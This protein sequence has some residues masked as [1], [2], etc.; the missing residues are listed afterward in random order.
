MDGILFGENSAPLSLRA[1]FK[2]EFLQTGEVVAPEVLYTL[3]SY[4]SEFTLGLTPHFVDIAND[5]K[6]LM[7]AGTIV[8]VGSNSGSFLDACAANGLSALGIEP[9]SALV[10]LC[11]QRG[12]RAVCSYFSQESA[13]QLQSSGEKFSA[14]Y[15]ANTLANIDDVA[16]FFE[17][18]ALLLDKG[19][20]IIVDTQDQ[21]A[22]IEHCLVDTVYHEHLSYFSPKSLAIAGRKFGFSVTG[23]RRNSSK[24]G[25]FTLYLTKSDAEHILLEEGR[26]TAATMAK[27]VEDIDGL[28]KRV[29]RF[30][31][32]TNG[33][34][35]AFGASV[36]CSMLVNWLKLDDVCTLVVDDNPQ[37]DALLGQSRNVP[38]RASKEIGVDTKADVLILAH[39]YENSIRPKFAKHHGLRFYNP[40]K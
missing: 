3:F 6:S 15:V 27:F 33:N 37:I 40:W 2:C 25:S 32:G 14:V 5:V 23:V 9:S 7:P 20:L 12:L 22:V 34:K 36:G 4:Q 17:A 39:R 31:D 13:R 21:A 8:E 18:S 30:F 19:G 28:K 29:A 1:C 16:S 10:E 24:G 26:L 38:V 35:F 11:K